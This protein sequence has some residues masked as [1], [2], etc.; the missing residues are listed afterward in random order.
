MKIIS[1][2]SLNIQVFLCFYKITHDEIANWDNVSKPSYT[3]EMNKEFEKVG[4]APNHPE[5]TQA[6]MKVKIGFDNLI[7]N[8]LEKE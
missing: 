4:G 3:F 8:S 2:K 1:K 7:F 5:A 6:A